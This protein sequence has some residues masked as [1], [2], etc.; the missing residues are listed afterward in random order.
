MG[1]E[2]I[3]IIAPAME[4]LRQAAINAT[5]PYPPDIMFTPRARSG[6]D[7]AVCMYHGQAPNPLKTME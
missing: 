3:D 2:A 7:V 4:R 6:Y 5:G 1:R